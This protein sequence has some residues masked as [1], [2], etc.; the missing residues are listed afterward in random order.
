MFPYQGVFQGVRT[1]NRLK[2]VVFWMLVIMSCIALGF[3]W[4]GVL[5][6]D[7]WLLY[8]AAAREKVSLLWAFGSA[9]AACAAVW[10]V[11]ALVVR[12][13]GALRE[14]DPDFA[15]DFERFETDHFPDSPQKPR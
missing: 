8:G 15:Y 6:V 4:V 9:F 1:M 2:N 10:A 13:F 12:M 7:E 14:N 11:A 5:A 3:G